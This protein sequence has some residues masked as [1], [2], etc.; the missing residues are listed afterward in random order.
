[1]TLV[2]QQG[3]QYYIPFNLYQDKTELTDQ[4]TTD[5]KIK[6]GNVSL[7]SSNGGLTYSEYEYGGKTSHAWMFPITESQ[8]LSWGAGMVSYQAGVKIDDAIILSEVGLVEVN[9][10][11]FGEAW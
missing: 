2:V 5:V 9:S 8:T 1:M 7:K 6:L 3:D 11:I 10:S 4:N